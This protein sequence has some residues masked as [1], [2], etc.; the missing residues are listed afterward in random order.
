MTLI[1]D[2]NFRGRKIGKDLMLYV[3]KYAKQN[4]CIWIDLTSNKKREAAGA[5]RFYESIGFENV[6]MTETNYLKKDI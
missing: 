3:E 1:V 4:D 6:G 2:E 5:L